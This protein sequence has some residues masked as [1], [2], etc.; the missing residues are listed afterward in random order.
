[1]S[2]RS[3]LIPLM[4]L[5]GSVATLALA[6]QS[7]SPVN[8]A[9][10]AVAKPPA[11]PAAASAPAAPMQNVAGV[12]T[13]IAADRIV[14]K[15]ET[16]EAITIHFD[17]RTRFIK[18][19]V[20]PPAPVKPETAPGAVTSAAGK[21]ASA[22]VTPVPATAQPAAPT[23]LFQPQRL[24]PQPLKPTEIVVGATLVAIG[25]LDAAK[26]TVAAHMVVQIPPERVQQM[27]A[28]R[29]SFGK[30]WLAGRVSVVEGNRIT[31]IGGP[32]HQAHSFEVDAKTAYRQGN[33]SAV[34]SDLKEGALVR[35]EGALAGERFVATSVLIVNRPLPPPSAPAAVAKPPAKP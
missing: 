25:E 19:V 24:V 14:L 16:G 8:G 31:L 6:E 1:M 4:L 22:P 5:A 11:A 18:Q 30:S 7:K 33:A 20:V 9:Q 21:E 29:E 15:P 17:D 27:R 13:E 2:Y 28:L 32:D 10:P 23:S 34:R 26:H 35:A 3:R 12:V